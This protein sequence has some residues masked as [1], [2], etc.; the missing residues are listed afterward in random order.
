[1][2]AA[3]TIAEFT[4]LIGGDTEY[5]RVA[6]LDMDGTVST[7]EELVVTRAIER[8]TSEAYS[9]LGVRFG[10]PLSD[11]AVTDALKGHVAEIA[12]YYLAPTSEASSEH[13]TARYKAACS[14][15][16]AVARREAQLGGDTTSPPAN[17]AIDVEHSGDTRLFTSTHLADLM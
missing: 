9:L 17:Q 8:A 3:I 2:P 5:L 13:L 16:K 12:R 15:C 7:A 14:W 11:A 4:V 6:D 10:T 1:M